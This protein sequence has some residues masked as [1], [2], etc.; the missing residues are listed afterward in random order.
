MGRI[1]SRKRL[2]NIDSGK[3]AEVWA[4]ETFSFSIS[5]ESELES[6]LSRFY[7]KMIITTG[8]LLDFY[9]YAHFFHEEN[10][11]SPKCCS[12]K[13]YRHG[14]QLAK[15]VLI[16]RSCPSMAMG[17]SSIRNQARLNTNN[18]SRAA[19]TDSQHC[20]AIFPKHTTSHRVDGFKLG[21]AD[22]IKLRLFPTLMFEKYPGNENYWFYHIETDKENTG[23]P[24]II[25]LIQVGLGRSMSEE[26]ICSIR[27]SMK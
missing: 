7:K 16:E 4:A 26:T 10:R 22:G 12:N 3:D 21:S 11:F 6:L 15:I 14:I 2:Q 20:W 13:H 17:I 24:E 8:L 19:P 18:R 27:R 25:Q 5:T 1:C 23:K 9:F